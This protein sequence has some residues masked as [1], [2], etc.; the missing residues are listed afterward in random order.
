MEQDRAG[1]AAQTYVDTP[2]GIFTASGVWFRT[3]EA[4]LVSYAGPVLRRVPLP[5]L[6]A[7]AEA[8][9]RSPETL[10]LW[11]LPVL[12]WWVPPVPAVTGALGL[13]LGWSL[14]SPAWVSPGLDRLVRLLSRVEVQAIY[15]VVWLSGMALSGRQA[16]LW[17]GVAGFVVI[18]WGGLARVLG[19]VIDRLHRRLYPLPRADQVLRALIVRL[20][21]KHRLSLPE[22]DQMEARI[23]KTWSK[24]TSKSSP[25]YP[26][27]PR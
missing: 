22:L 11:C 18:R 16:A 19:P 8:W 5:G 9:L 6:L 25:T 27:K 17:T 21:L 12:L 7:R 13:Y 10:V 24:R 15:Y 3:R 23:L 1:T 26:P 14:L 4:D 20:A 2:K